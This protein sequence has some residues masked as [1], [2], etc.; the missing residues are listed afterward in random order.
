MGKKLLIL[1]IW[2]GVAPNLPFNLNATALAAES[3]VQARVGQIVTAEGL[4]IQVK[5]V[6]EDSR[7]PRG[8][9]CFWQ[10]RLTVEVQLDPGNE[11]TS[12]RLKSDQPATFKAWTLSLAE[13]SPAPRKGEKWPARAY[14]FRFN[15]KKD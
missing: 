7:C 12:L 10:G 13:A 8:V 1:W 15:V 6:L 9:H 2:L 5:Q 11:P 3:T 14:R 4:R